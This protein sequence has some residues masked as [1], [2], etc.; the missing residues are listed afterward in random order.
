MKRVFLIVLDSLGIGEMADAKGYNDEGSNTLAAILPFCLGGLPTLEKL[1]LF[2]IDGTPDLPS[3]TPFAPPFA[4]VAR[5]TEQSA[6]KDTTLGHWELAGVVSKRPLPTYPNGFP[7]EI[8]RAF[9]ESTGRGVLCNRPYS[10]TE[11]IHDYGEEHRKSGD[12]IVYTSADSVFQIAAHEEIIPLEKLYEACQIARELLKGAHGVG[13][14]IARPFRGTFPNFVRTEHRHDFSLK[15]P[16]NTMLD[17]LRQKGLDTLAIGKIYDIFAGCGITEHFPTASNEEGMRT[18]DTLLTRGFHGLTFCNL[19]DFDMIYGHRNDAVGYAAALQT[20]DR[21][22]SDFLPKLGKEDL[23]IVTADHG[24]DPQTPSTDHSR[25]YVPCLVYQ[26]G[27]AGKNLGTRNT[28][29][30]VAAT[31]LHHL[32]LPS[33]FSHAKSLLTDD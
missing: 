18:L 20:F 17:V 29:S 1:G 7:E 24:C 27:I 14:V 8:I 26:A 28:F 5:L 31:V 22:L 3:S 33:P 15:P 16:H 21:W 2:C 11:V 9:C 12:W 4:R 25:E 13:R 6:G 32:D 19:V 23:L 30:D 10:G